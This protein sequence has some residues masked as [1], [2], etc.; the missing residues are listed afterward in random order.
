M[1]HLLVKIIQNSKFKKKIFKIQNYLWP[2]IHILIW[3][4]IH[5]FGECQKRTVLIIH[6]SVWFKI[7]K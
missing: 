7:V 3:K 6:V 1:L 2:K 4:Y 5:D